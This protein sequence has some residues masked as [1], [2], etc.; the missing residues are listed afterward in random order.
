TRKLSA[1]ACATRELRKASGD[2]DT[3]AATEASG[4]AAAKAK[5]AAAAGPVAQQV[6]PDDGKALWA[7]P[8]TG[9][10]VTFRCVP[11]EGQV[12]LILRPAE[13]LAND[14]GR[15]VIAALGPV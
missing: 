3:N 12:F 10:P 15:R 11:P 4:N 8:T 13:M 14:E 7:S 9:K 6:V 1:R 2:A 5:T